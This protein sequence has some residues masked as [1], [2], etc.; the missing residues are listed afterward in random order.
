M[1]EEV[2]RRTPKLK[3]K[4][5]YKPFHTLPESYLGTPTTLIGLVA[6]CSIAGHFYPAIEVFSPSL[7]E[8]CCSVVHYTI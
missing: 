4:L 8:Y 3:R 5:V 6:I 1:S 7:F 2:F